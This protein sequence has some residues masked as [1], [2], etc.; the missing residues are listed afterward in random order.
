MRISDWSSDVCS[1]DLDQVEVPLPLRRANADA[2]AVTLTATFQG[3]QDEGICYPPMTRTVRIALPA[4][5]ATVAVAAGNPIP[6]PALPLKG[7]E[8]EQAAADTSANA[9][10]APDPEPSPSRGGLGGDGF[11]VATANPPAGNAPAA[12]A[13]TSAELADDTRLAA[14]LTGPERWLT[15]PVFFLGGLVLAFTPLPLPIIPTLSGRTP[16]PA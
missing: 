8:Q 6:T 10:S 12:D 16:G 5:D 3:C 13:G 1:S 14:A 15:L 11:P 2:Q 7:R 4:G 9:A